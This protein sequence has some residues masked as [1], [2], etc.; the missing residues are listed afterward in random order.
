MQSAP[1]LGMCW[2][3]QNIISTARKM[4]GITNPSEAE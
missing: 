3:G 4:I 1:V 2:Q